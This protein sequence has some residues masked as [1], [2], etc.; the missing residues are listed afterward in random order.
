[1]SQQSSYVINM[2]KYI[3]SKTISPNELRNQGGP[4]II[5]SA[6]S[7]L[8]K[9]SLSEFSGNTEQEFVKL[10]NDKTFE[11]VKRLPIKSNHWGSARKVLNLFMRDV[12]YN[13][14]LNKY[15]NLETVSKLLEIPLDAKTAKMIKKNYKD[16]KLPNFQS[17]KNL[18]P[19]VNSN[20]Q[21]AA[22]IIAKK[23]ET[24][25]VDLLLLTELF[26]N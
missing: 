10:L 13:T 5:E 7:F 2:Q 15:Y 1:M 17:V 26:D 20:Y 4:P 9:I 21:I 18:S 6:I 14:I 23:F 25:R 12:T 24:H 3:A 16:D 11:L 19:N 22:N 8:N